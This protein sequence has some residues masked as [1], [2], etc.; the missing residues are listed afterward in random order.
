MNGVRED[1]VEAERARG[2]ALA[3]AGMHASIAMTTC[4]TYVVEARQYLSIEVRH[5]LDAALAVYGGT[6]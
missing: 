4:N 2:K 5:Q 3:E 6:T 1:A